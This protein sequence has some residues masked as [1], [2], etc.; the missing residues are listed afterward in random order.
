MR[1]ISLLSDWIITLFL[2][3]YNKETF[4]STVF[5]IV[6]LLIMQ[7]LFLHFCLCFVCNL[8]Q[9]WWRY[10]S[11][12]KFNLT[13]PMLENMIIWPW[14]FCNIYENH[15]MFLIMVNINL[16]FLTWES[17]WSNGQHIHFQSMMSLDLNPSQGGSECPTLISSG[18]MI[19]ISNLIWAR[20]VKGG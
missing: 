13:T 1:D 8:C 18:L 3:N 4:L 10:K 19:R 9:C 20:N 16:I 12:R 6:T 7:S 15:L 14:L 2:Y 11:M 5:T 17:R